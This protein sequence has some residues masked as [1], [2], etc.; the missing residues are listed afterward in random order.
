MSPTSSPS[1]TPTSSSSS[2][3]TKV[4]I[5][6][7]PGRLCH[8]TAHEKFEPKTTGITSICTNLKSKTDIER[9]KLESL[10]AQSGNRRNGTHGAVGT[11][12]L[13]PWDSTGQQG[14]GAH[15]EVRRPAD[16]NA[17]H[18]A[19]NCGAASRES[20]SAAKFCSAQWRHCFRMYNVQFNGETAA[21]ECTLLSTRLQCKLLLRFTFLCFSPF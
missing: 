18:Y 3:H 14:G 11:P 12:N 13:H 1:S 7:L 9:V 2:S 20:R 16:N 4:Q 10:C 19:T 8:L 15:W 21:S 17:A 5:P 6:T